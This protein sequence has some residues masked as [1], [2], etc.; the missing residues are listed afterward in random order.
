MPKPHLLSPSRFQEV[1][2]S[3]I[4][5]TFKPGYPPAK[6]LPDYSTIIL[7]ENRFVGMP[8]Y[9]V[10]EKCLIQVSR[11]ANNFSNPNLV[12]C[13]IGTI[14][15]NAQNV[16]DIH[17]F[18]DPTFHTPVYPNT[19]TRVFAEDAFRDQVYD[20]RNILLPSIPLTP[21]NDTLYWRVVWLKNPDATI[22][23]P[24]DKVLAI[25]TIG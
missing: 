15:A 5:L 2:P 8:T 14:Q 20:D 19:I 10:Q 11:V 7:D 4:E 6:L 13:Q 25:F 18:N 9:I 22:L 24:S 23:T 3:V 17:D 1:N 12:H 21:E 16:T